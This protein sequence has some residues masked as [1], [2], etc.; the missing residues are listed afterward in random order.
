M[1]KRHL[2][3]QTRIIKRLS[4]R[5]KNARAF[6]PVVQSAFDSAYEAC[7]GVALYGETN[8]KV[9]NIFE[10]A[11]L[12]PR[13][14]EDWLT[15]LE[16]V[17]DVALSTTKQ[18]KWDDVRL[19]LLYADYQKIELERKKLTK[20][21]ASRRLIEAHPHRYRTLNPKSLSRLLTRAQR[22]MERSTT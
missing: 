10:S 12:N 3:R 13:K 4:A 6:D 9:R 2:D 19:K 1:T 22:L 20:I 7:V 5:L 16:A 8:P 15:V 18:S 14:L 11:Q 17:L 21:A